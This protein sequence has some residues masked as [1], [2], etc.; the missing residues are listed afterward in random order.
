MSLQQNSNS[1]LPTSSPLNS[2]FEETL[3][4][5]WRKQWDEYGRPFY[6]DE[7]TKCTTWECPLSPLPPGYF[8]K[9]NKSDH[10]F[11]FFMWYDRIQ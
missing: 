2:E 5:G 10:I 4:V 11:S 6:V 1:L 7:N 3:L 9:F 8:L